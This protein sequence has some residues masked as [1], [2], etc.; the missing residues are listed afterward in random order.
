MDPKC[1][2]II[3]V[4]SKEKL[5]LSWVRFGQ[6]SVREVYTQSKGVKF[7]VELQ[8]NWLKDDS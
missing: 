5:D 2:R 1:P 6:I 4:I 8:E 3:I 7:Q